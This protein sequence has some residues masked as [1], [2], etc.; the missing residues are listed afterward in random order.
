MRWV[1]LVLG[2][3]AGAAIGWRLH[4]APAVGDVWAAAQRVA[5][6]DGGRSDDARA[7]L[8]PA[9][10]RTGGQGGDGAPDETQAAMALLPADE[11]AV[12]V[13][14][15]GAQGGTARLPAEPAAAG[16][17]DG[18]ERGG[19]R[20]DRSGASMPVGR[21]EGAAPDG[22]PTEGSD[23]RI[24]PVEVDGIDAVV[25]R[26]AEDGRTRAAA[27]R[28]RARGAAALAAAIER[29]DARRRAA[30]GALLEGALEEA[31][32]RAA[33]A[34]AMEGE[35]GLRGR[36]AADRQMAARIAGAFHE[37]ALVHEARGQF[38]QARAA[39]ERA[40]AVDPSHFDSLAGLQRLPL[41]D[42]AARPSR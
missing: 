19:Q 10:R 9:D 31:A 40:L 20:R 26:W 23:D 4:R 42:P 28:L 18:A 15:G 36:T 1:L 41:P 3:I 6:D 30:Q 5:P 38:G 22:R 37:R 35:L 7:A 29:V 12:G 17:I 24:G 25:A 2:G 11:G 33:E 8:R 16:A 27:T 34:R 14:G 13:R 32:A 39:W 21:S